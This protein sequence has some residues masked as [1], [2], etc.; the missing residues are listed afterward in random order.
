MKSL[1]EQTKEN[2]CLIE[3]RHDFIRIV[4]IIKKRSKIIKDNESFLP[5]VPYYNIWRR[6]SSCKN[7][8]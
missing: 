7:C 8:I 3:S 5:E 4:D 6:G 2:V 1:S